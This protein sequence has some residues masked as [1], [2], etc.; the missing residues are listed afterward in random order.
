[1]AHQSMTTDACL[2]QTGAIASILGVLVLAVS[3]FLHPLQAD[4]N[5]A[6]AAF[7]EYAA[8][9]LWVWSH[10]GQFV[11]V[12]F[13][14]IGLVG[15]AATLEAGKPAAA[16]RIATVG[17]AATIASAAALQAVDGVALKV[18]VDRWAAAEGAERDLAFEAAFAV[19][20]I[21]IGLAALL[22]IVFGLTAAAFGAA[23]LWSARYPSWL[24]GLA[25]AGAAAMIATGLAHATTG[26]SELAMML[27]MVSSLMLIVWF[28]ALAPILWRRADEP[29]E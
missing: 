29:T 11:G 16:A 17:I 15:L 20:Q 8:D 18:T 26:F 28:V 14:G 1:M 3:T 25:L 5:D 23:L 6:S 9:Q 22:P 21:E 4:P 24:G 19:R 27:S 2:A 12:V 13:L 7:A 10:L